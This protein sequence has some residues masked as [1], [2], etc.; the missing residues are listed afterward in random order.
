MP[1]CSRYFTTVR[2]AISALLLERIGELLVAERLRLVLGIDDL[3]EHLLD[4]LPALLL[5]VVPRLA[6]TREEAA[7]RIHPPRRLHPLLADRPT[8]RRDVD[9][10]AIRDLGHR[11]GLEEL[12]SMVE[13][14][15]GAPGRLGPPQGVRSLV[16]RID[17]PAGIADRGVD[18]LLALGIDPGSSRIRSTC[19]LIGTGIPSA[20]APRTGRCR[21]RTRRSR[22][23]P[24]TGRRDS[25]V[26]PDAASAPWPPGPARATSPR[27]SPPWEAGS[28][29][30]R[31]SARR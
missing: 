18:E 8:D 22:R 31:R 17:Q 15:A 2:R 27:P 28:G 9:P 10:E 11:E 24:R 25:R 14:P 13:E 12:R 30:G 3:A 4:R 23:A 26:R 21:A 7:E 6:S 5:P 19:G 16:D 29:R 1:S 20:S